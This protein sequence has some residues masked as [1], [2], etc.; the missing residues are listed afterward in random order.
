M[1]DT[2]MLKSSGRPRAFDK[3][4]GIETAMRLF[5]ERGYEGVGVAELA[6]AIGI[7]P[8]SLY[9][10]YGSKRGLFAR[11]VERYGQTK[12]AFFARLFEDRPLADVLG[13]VLAEARDVYTSDDACKGCLIMN[14]TAGSGDAEVCAITS[15]RKD[16]LRAAVKGLA[17]TRGAANPGEVADYFL[18]LLTGLSASARD[19]AGPAQLDRDL[20]L[21]MVGLRAA[22][23]A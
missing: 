13:D 12:G 14:G 6:K 2:K 3:D 21:A 23:A 10:A 17:E 20:A 18:F 19:G 4:A 8:P 15:A 5:W 9:A 11:A 7:N 1:T 16:E 22:L